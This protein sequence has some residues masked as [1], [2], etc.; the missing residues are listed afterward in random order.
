MHWYDTIRAT[1][2]AIVCATLLGPILAVQIQVWLDKRRGKQNRRILI[3]QALMRTRASTLAPDHV[4][5]LN[6]VPVEFYGIKPITDA[7]YLLIGH[8]NSPQNEVWGTR[9]IDL[10]MDLLH[11]I[12]QEL[13]YDF[14]VAQLKGEYYA[15]KGHFDVETQLNAIRE[16]LAKILSGDAAF[17]MEVKKFPGDPEAQAALKA[18]LKGEGVL[19]VNTTNLGG[20][21]GIPPQHHD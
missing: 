15:P 19:R 21:H 4:N 16:G 11:R 10:F 12:S 2:I 20:H 1:D 5:A 6:A 9:R 8:L 14:T 18:L 13:G 3:F 7:Y 17:P